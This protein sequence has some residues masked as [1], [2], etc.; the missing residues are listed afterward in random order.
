MS[1]L[2][3]IIHAN[4][5]YTASVEKRVSDAKEDRSLQERLRKEWEKRVAIPNR[6]LLTGFEVP[7]LALPDMDH[8]A[9]IARFLGEWG[10]PG[11]FPYGLSIYPTAFV[12]TD[13]GPR[14]EEPTRMFAGLGDPKMTNDRF[15]LVTSRQRSKRLST[16]FDTNTLMGRDADDPDY[17]IDIGEG[18]VSV[19]TFEDVK[20]LFDGFFQDPTSISMTING[21]SVWMT[22]ARLRAAVD[23]G[24]KLENI[25]GTS[26]TDP[27]K[28]DDAQNELIF[29]LDKSIKIAMDMFEW[30]VRKAPKYYPINVSGYHI[31][32]KGATPVE[33]AAFTLANG[34]VYIDEAKKRGISPTEA[35][36]R[37]PFFFT[38]GFDLEYIALLSA[39]RRVWSVALRDA[40]GVAEPNAQKLKCHIQTS[41]RS[42]YEREILNN[43]TRTALELFYA[44]L[45]YP[46]SLHSNSYDEPITTPTEGA[47]QIASDAQAILLEE[48]G[49]FK[50]MMGFLSDSSGRLTVYR[51]LIRG[52]LDLFKQMEEFG[53]ILEAKAGGFFRDRIAA[54]SGL[55]EE[56]VRTGKRRIVG[57]SA[58]VE[59]RKDTAG[60]AR[61]QIPDDLKKKHAGAVARFKK[62]RD[63]E[64][65]KTCLHRLRETASSGG[66]VFDVT[67]DIVPHVTLG[68]WTYALQQVYGIFRRRK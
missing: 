53:G 56:Q 38:S 10:M 23:S 3:E 65:V 15:R 26:Q 52:V 37:L 31:E 49:G 17:L 25:R 51:N 46:Q 41:G 43:I 54:S 2:K 36:P 24:Q 22:A 33:Q 47:V 21:P 66:N 59:G 12:V 48:A 40:Y 13:E 30:C 39:A 5:A 57:V 64:K 28:E 63:P 19:S 29:P 55:Y 34:F 6:K 11:E 61:V 16:A 42:L 8:P 27:C 20:T 9:Q 62:N 58:Y 67:F 50:D 60:I 68:E 32:Q 14:F 7:L 35:A 18:G 44:L 4:E 45:N 1:S